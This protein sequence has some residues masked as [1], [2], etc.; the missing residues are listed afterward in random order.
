[1]TTPAKPPRP[2]ASGGPRTWVNWAGNV[3]CTPARVEYPTTPTEV[4]WVLDRARQDGR[5]VRPVGSGHSFT[6]AAQ[7][8]GVLVDLRAMSGLDGI[9]RLAAPPNDALP[10]TCARVWVRAGTT[11]HDLNAMLAHLGLAM[12]NLG[13]IDGQ[14]LAG[15]ASTGTH[16]TGARFTGI[17]GFVSGLRLV[18]P[19][20]NL[21]ECSREDRSELF[22]AALVGLGAFGIVVALRVDVV[23][24]FRIH[25][26]ERPESLAAVFERIDTLPGEA[27]HVEFFWFPGTDRVSAKFNTRLAAHDLSGTPLPPWRRV[28]D[29]EVLCNGL[30]G[31]INRL[32]ARM[33]RLVP[34]LNE[35]S[36]RGLSA[37]T[38]TA[39]SSEVFISSRRVKFRETEYALPIEA[40]GDVLRA[41]VT[42]LGR[43]RITTTFPLEVR[44]AGA[45]DAWLSTG[46]ER[47]NVYIAAHEYVGSASQDYFEVL[48]NIFDAYEG[49]PHWGKLHRLDAARFAELYPRF[50]DVRRVRADVDPDGLLRNPYLDRVLGP[51]G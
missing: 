26:Q 8:D 21:V 5:T 13:D 50:G 20:G 49:R 41:V 3:S 43:R 28:L 31:G 17:A 32:G 37:R 9:E 15:A 48:Q 51:I 10:E 30:F 6:P 14:T 24:A 40:A 42:E 1:M 34:A 27:D 36:A 39:G 46:F 47:R 45:D 35:V 2:S 12:P 44:F 29:D 25:A 18:L 7:T 22:H 23:P 11:L 38:Y 19:D 33:P 4:T 16:G